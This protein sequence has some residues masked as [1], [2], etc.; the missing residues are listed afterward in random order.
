MATV[1]GKYARFNIAKEKNSVKQEFWQAEKRAG[2]N[3]SGA[4]LKADSEKMKKDEE[5][6]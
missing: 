1:T 5:K 4:I 3:Y 2:E 6:Y